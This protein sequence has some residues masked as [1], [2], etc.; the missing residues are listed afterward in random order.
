VT[1]GGGE[2]GAGGRESPGETDTVF[3]ARHARSEV[4]CFDEKLQEVAVLN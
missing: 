2:G 1:R 4:W 3:R